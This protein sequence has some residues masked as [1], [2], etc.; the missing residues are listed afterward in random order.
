MRFEHFIAQA[1]TPT[2]LA[3][4]DAV[5]W[6]LSLS[7]IPNLPSL[8]P[9]LSARGEVTS[10]CVQP[11]NTQTLHRVS[12]PP[13]SGDYNHGPGQENVQ[14]KR[15]G[16]G[17][18]LRLRLARTC[19]RD[20][21]R[22]ASP[23]G[24]IQRI[25]VETRETSRGLFVPLCLAPTGQ[26]AQAFGYARPLKLN[27]NCPLDDCVKETLLGNPTRILIS[28]ELE[29]DEMQTQVLYFNVTVKY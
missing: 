26:S 8:T 14:P 3:D 11:S 6:G 10:A 15:N 7:E 12:D 2:A 27:L 17:R 4:G 9:R 20:N 1:H 22:T 5:V 25:P 18:S 29:T 28:V 23:T 13:H 24:R 16:P 19:G 21:D